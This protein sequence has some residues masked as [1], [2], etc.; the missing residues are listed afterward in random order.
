MADPLTAYCG[1]DW[2]RH[3]DRSTLTPVATE[4]V[5]ADPRLRRNDLIWRATWRGRALYLYLMLEFQ[6]K[7]ER[8]MPLR[9]AEYVL[10]LYNWLLASGQVR[11]RGL[12]PPVLATVVYNGKKPWAG[13][14]E[15][16]GLGY[17]VP[18]ALKAFQIHELI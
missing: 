3:L 12:L 13:P 16:A 10:Q 14:L 18:E 17:R 9:V 7:S 8:R 2:A 6:S 1:A 5:A 15:M 11:G 4:H